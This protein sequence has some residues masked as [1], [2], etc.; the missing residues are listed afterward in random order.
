MPRLSSFYLPQKS[1]SAPPPKPIPRGSSRPGS[2]LRRQ[3]HPR[4]AA[5]RSPMSASSRVGAPSAV[6]VLA[7]ATPRPS[8]LSLLHRPAKMGSGMS[9]RGRRSEYINQI[10]EDLTLWKCSADDLLI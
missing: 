8:K 5:S 6:G 2:A 4:P 10:F 7:V 9:R 3:L 1:Q